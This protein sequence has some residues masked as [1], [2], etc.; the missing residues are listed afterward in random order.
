MVPRPLLSNVSAL[1]AS[2]ALPFAFQP[3]GR[4]G[5][6]IHATFPFEIQKDFSEDFFFLSLH[7]NAAKC[8]KYFNLFFFHVENILVCPYYV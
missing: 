6:T 5:E 4:V 8:R 2:A 7:F 1:W 3:E